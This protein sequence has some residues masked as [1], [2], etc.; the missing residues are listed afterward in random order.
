MQAFLLLRGCYELSYAYIQC[1]RLCAHMYA[2]ILLVSMDQAACP[3]G[4]GLKPTAKA[5][6]SGQ[7]YVC[8]RAAVSLEST[9]FYRCRGLG[10][11]VHSM[12]GSQVR[13]T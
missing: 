6:V 13:T 7:P 2:C 12:D 3:T 9:G 11:Y 10:T 4:F 5:I 1:V 8:E